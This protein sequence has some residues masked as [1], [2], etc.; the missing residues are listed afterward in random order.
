MGKGQNL[1]WGLGR[2]VGA[3]SFDRSAPD[4]TIQRAK[5]AVRRQTQLIKGRISSGDTTVT[6]REAGAEI[7]VSPDKLRSQ[8]YF[9]RLLA[10]FPFLS[11]MFTANFVS[12]LLF[13]LS[14]FSPLFLLFYFSRI[15]LLRPLSSSATLCP[16]WKPF[17][18]LVLI[19][20]LTSSISSI[21]L[22]FPQFLEWGDIFHC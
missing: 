18:L 22:S 21:F 9:L 3:I 14:S 7:Q 1:D 17:L 2:A 6:E 8:A 12:F 15:I 4:C 16:I 5:R 13:L 20:P 19:F 11:S 10:F